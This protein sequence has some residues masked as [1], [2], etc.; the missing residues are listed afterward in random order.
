MSSPSTLRSSGLCRRVV[1][2]WYQSFRG[3]Y[4]PIFTVELNQ[5]G[6]VVSYGGERVT[7][8]YVARQ[9]H[10]WGKWGMEPRRAS[11]PNMANLRHNIIT[12][13]FQFTV[14]CRDV[15][16]ISPDT[17]GRGQGLH[18]PVSP[19]TALILHSPHP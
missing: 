10:N 6:K 13:R 17:E 19:F 11:T 15:T 8:I 2:C 1:G 3:T 9:T 16:A 4:N 5:V 7:K 14:F 18:P 12:C